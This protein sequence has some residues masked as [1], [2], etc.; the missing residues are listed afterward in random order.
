MIR[1][2]K[3]TDIKAIEG[4]IRRQ[5]ATSKYAGRVRISDKALDQLMVHLFAGQAQPSVGAT[6]ISVAVRDG[7]VVGFIAGI[8]QR[9]YLIGDKLEATDVFFV[10]EGSAADT[11][12]LA[13]AYLNWATGNRKVLEVR[14]SWTDSIPGASRV[15]ALFQRKGLRKSGEVWSLST[16]AVQKEAA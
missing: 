4:L 14:M 12:A 8:L 10:N 11:F 13:D 3:P 9:V 16:D 7:K 2:V 5:H 1:A 15:T 6:H